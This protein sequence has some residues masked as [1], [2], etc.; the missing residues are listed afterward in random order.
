MTEAE[1]R[2]AVCSQ[3]RAWLGLKESDGSHRQIID[4]YN[5]HRPA[6][7]YK[8]MYVDPWCAA[9]VSAVGMACGLK[10]VILP[11]VNCDGMIAAYQQQGRFVRNP[12]YNPMPGD[13]IFYDWDGNSRTDHVGIVFSVQDREITVIEGNRSDAVMYR[14]ITRGDGSIYGYAVP[15]Y[16]T[17]PAEQE[18]EPP[19]EE[20]VKPEPPA[21]IEGLPTLKKGDKGWAVKSAQ[22]ILIAHKFSCGPDG[23]DGDFGKNTEGAVLNFQ[24]KYLLTPDGIIGPATWT[25][26]LTGVM[27]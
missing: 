26:L 5:E 21:L 19:A 11:H 3:A 16:G 7:T 6:G 13:L 12:S 9:F 22:G 1:A 17:T 8:M 4:L 2:N 24:R 14:T 18:P 15:A 25:V 10:D 20:P 23:A 27:E